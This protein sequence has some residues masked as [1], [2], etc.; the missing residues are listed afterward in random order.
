MRSSALKL[1]LSIAVIGF[2][3]A[4]QAKDA[5]EQTTS[6][7]MAKLSPNYLSYDRLGM[8]IKWGTFTGVS[9]K[10]WSDDYQAVEISAAFA[11][12]NTIIGVDYL[13]NF[14]GAVANLVQ[15]K[16]VD[17]FI[18][19]AGVGLLSSFGTNSSNTRIFNRD[20]EAFALAAR[21]P[22]GIEFLP[23]SVHMGIYGEIGLGYSFIPNSY[24]FATAD[25]GARYYF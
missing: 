22:I 10:Y 11:D 9:A 19:F 3:Q 13:W 23:S 2:A 15:F 25:V 4:S 14:R 8:G 17:N 16:G 7:T 1:A 21:I 5:A 6:A 24:S 12:A 18:P 20:T